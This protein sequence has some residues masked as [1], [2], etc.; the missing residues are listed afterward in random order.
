MVDGVEGNKTFRLVSNIQHDS[1]WTYNTTYESR[2]E[3]PYYKDVTFPATFSTDA[4]MLLAV[5]VRDY[6]NTE[7]LI[8][9]L[10]L[11]KGNKATDWTPASE[12]MATADA[13]GSVSESLA[14]LNIMAG[15]IAANVTKVE[16]KNTESIESLSESVNSLSQEVSAKMTAEAVELQIKSAMQSGTSKVV[17]STGYTFDD[18]GLTVQ[19]SGSEMK[20]QI[21]DNGMTVYQGGTEVLTANNTGVDAKNL[22]ATTYLIVGENSRFEDYGSGRTGCFWIGGTS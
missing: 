8:A 21:S 10:K 14:A 15:E 19:K 9:G 5:V 13:V 3:R 16:Q 4:D 12:D 20:T 22:H 18:E 17:T 7:Q 2:L 11:E 6:G 1:T